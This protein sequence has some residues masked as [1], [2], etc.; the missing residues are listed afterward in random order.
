LAEEKVAH[1]TAKHSL[2]TSDEARVTLAWHLESVEAS[3]T[4]TASK[5]ASKSSTLDTAVIWAHEMEIKLK[6]AEEWL[7]ATKEK[8][9]SQGQLLDS[10]Q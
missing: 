8:M 10:A 9:K 2:Q 5:L 6:V 3:L 4:T 7:M 1:Q